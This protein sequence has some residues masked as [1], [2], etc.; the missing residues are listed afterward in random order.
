[1]MNKT[2]RLLLLACL[3][4][5]SLSS[6]A[7]AQAQDEEEDWVLF[8]DESGLFTVEHPSDWFAL[9]DEEVPGI[10]LSNDEALLD[11]AAADQEA[12]SGQIRIQAAFFPTD[13][14]AL[15]GVALDDESLSEADKLT[16][17]TQ[18]LMTNAQDPNSTPDPESGDPVFGEAFELELEDETLLALIP[19]TQESNN[20]EG[21]FTAFE[22]AEGIYVIAN[23]G[24]FTDEMTDE[25]R[26]LAIEI[27]KSIEF[28][29][30]V[31]DLMA[32]YGL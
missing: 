27:L 1:M 26:D 11:P 5:M 3:L 9:G 31:E 29:G 14:L 28:T 24:A 19:V 22:V 2:L 25:T 18:T 8:E 17:I 32:A 13:F 6:L 15:M 10:T 7:L 21:Y 30:T 16:L 23:I 4:L 12:E 20:A